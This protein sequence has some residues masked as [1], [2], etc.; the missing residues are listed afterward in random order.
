[1]K[2]DA[3][4]LAGSENK[5]KLTEISSCRYEALIPIHGRS[6]I[7][8]VIAALRTSEKVGNIAV[9]GPGELRSSLAEDIA[10]VPSADSFSDNIQ[11]G[12]GHFSHRERVLLVTSDIPLLHREALEDF[13]QRCGDFSKDIYYPIVS[14]EANERRFPG[15]P[16][17]YVRT[18]DGVFTGGNIMLVSPAAVRECKDT[19]E[20]IVALRKKPW[21]LFR[22]LGFW[23]IVRFV[24]RRAAL[25]EFERRVEEILDVKASAVVSP[26]PEIG[27]DVD[28]PADWALACRELAP[29]ADQKEALPCGE[30]SE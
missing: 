21:I 6:M 29:A 7:S 9:V 10:L 11:R 18:K 24:F 14:R 12:V 30:V 16:R 1:M 28:K 26:Y 27:T 22:M 15:V 5:G 17:T 8:Y 19:V 23:F 13:L 2:I 3:I 4:V 20:R 25:R